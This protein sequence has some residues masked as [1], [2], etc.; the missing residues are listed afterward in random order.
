M[1][2]IGTG[3]GLFV[4]ESAR[5]N[6]T[7]FYIGV[8]ANARP[9]EKISEK[10]YRKPFTTLPGGGPNALFVQAAIEELPPELDGIADEV[11]VHFP[12]G[13][14]LRA[15]AGGEQESLQR[16]R[17]ICSPGARLVVI[18][19]LDPTRDRTEVLRLGLEPFSLAYIDSSLTASYRKC[20]FEVVERGMLSAAEWA[21]LE[22]SWARRLRGDGSRSVFYLHA[23]AVDWVGL[24]GSVARRNSGLP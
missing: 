2:D 20:G 9:L 4:Y 16:L 23:L 8:D 6:P 5:R 10:I 1:I 18:I 22:S 7:R 14:L 3:D 17:R 19:G 13:G 11:R 15:V 24:S 21:S 12:W